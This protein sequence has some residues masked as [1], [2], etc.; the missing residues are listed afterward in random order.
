MTSPGCCSTVN[1]ATRSLPW[2]LDAISNCLMEHP[3]AFTLQT[4]YPHMM[5]LRVHLLF[6]PAMYFNFSNYERAVE[7]YRLGLQWGAG[8]PEVSVGALLQRMQ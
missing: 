5:T 1:S 3:D 2:D 8:V 6:V 7:E 4:A